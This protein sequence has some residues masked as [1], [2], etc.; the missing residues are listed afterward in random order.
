MS[1]SNLGNAIREYRKKN[2]LT[3]K[4]LAEKL[5]KAESTVR[6]WELG[7]NKPIPDVLRQLSNA[8]N[9]SY[10]ELMEKAGY[11]NESD[12]MEILQT[13]LF[14]LEE[15]KMHKKIKFDS[16]THELSR[17]DLNDETRKHLREVYE[18]SYS[19][20]Q[21]IDNAIASL[22]DLIKSSEEYKEAKEAQNLIQSFAG[23]AETEVD[24]ENLF[25]IAKE[26][27]IGG[28]TLSPQEKEQA[29]RILK[30]TFY[31]DNK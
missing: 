15:T 13:Q 31:N 26:I 11:T 28:K 23:K 29:L 19:E 22:T 30:A 14:A 2:K 25:N 21:K 4:E 5:D 27:T 20:L 10:S 1:N 8:L 17:S 7:K 16:V 3:Q 9:V 24:L 12:K 6:M 18:E